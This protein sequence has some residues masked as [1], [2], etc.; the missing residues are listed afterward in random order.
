MD[1]QE[2]KARGKAAIE[3][4][5]KRQEPKTQ[6]QRVHNKKP[7][8]EV[9]KA[10]LAWMRE[11]GW[12]VAIYESKATYSEAAG[13]YVS[14]SM[15]AGNADC[16]G[17]LPGGIGVVVEFKAPAKLSTFAAEKNYRQQEFI[18]A[19]IDAGCFACVTDSVERLAEIFAVWSQ[20]RS[21]HGIDEAARYLHEQ[22]PKRKR[23]K[24]DD[25]PLF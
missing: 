15:K 23:T 7:E 14:Q 1:E 6:R 19:K 9:E 20:K 3:R 24:R 21:S 11:K 17:H 22:L 4:Y 18:K 2:R 5:Y 10:C 25:E 12:T 8:K 16:M 13:R